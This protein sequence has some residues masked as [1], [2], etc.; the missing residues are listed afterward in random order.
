MEFLAFERWLNKWDG[1]QDHDSETLLAEGVQLAVQRRTALAKLIQFDPQKAL[2][3]ALPASI[4]TR[5]PHE[6]VNELEVPVC[7]RGSYE[8]LIRRSAFGEPASVTRSVEFEGKRYRAFVYGRRER[9]RSK[10][11]IPLHGIAIGDLLALHEHPSRTTL[12]HSP[13]FE[14]PVV[15]VQA[16]NKRVLFES[17]PDAQVFDAQLIAQEDAPGPFAGSVQSEFLAASSRSAWTQGAK[18]LL[19]MRVDFSD[20]PGAPV[21][22]VVADTLIQDTAGFLFENSYGQLSLT[23]KVTPVLRMPKTAAYYANSGAAGQLLGDARAAAKA[24]GS[25]YDTKNFHFDAVATLGVFSYNGLGLL[26]GKGLWIHNKFT[27]EILAH[28]LGH[29]LGLDHANLWHTTDGSII[30]SGSNAEYADPFDM[31]GSV[32]TAQTHFN[33]Y[34]KNLLGW[35]PSSQVTTVKTSGTYRIYA[36]DQALGNAAG[37]LKI[38]KDSRNYWVDF[39]QQIT[40]NP[41][42]MNGADI[43]W[44]PWGQSNGG[45]QLLDMRPDTASSTAQHDKPLTIGMTFSDRENNIHVTPIGKGGTAPESL[46]IVVNFGAFANNFP[47]TLSLTPNAVT[48]AVDQSLDFMASATDPDGDTLAYYWEFGDL[49][50]GTNSANVSKSWSAPGEYIVRCVVTDMKGGTASAWVLV[51]VG[52]PTASYRITGHVYDQH[53]RPVQGVKVAMGFSPFVPSDSNGAFLVLAPPVSAGYYLLATKPGYSIAPSNFTNPIWVSGDLPGRDF[54]ANLL[55]DVND[56]PNASDDAYATNEDQVLVVSSAMGLL[57]NDQDLDGGALTVTLATPPSVG[58]ASLQ[59]NGGFTY[60]PPANFSGT[61]T[62]GYRA[63]DKTLHSLEATVTITVNAVNDAPSVVYSGDSELYGLAGVSVDL[64]AN[65]TDL[66][67]TVDH[68]VWNFGDGS[69]DLDAVPGLQVTHTFA[70]AGA[71]PITV[72]AIDDLG[73]AGPT[74]TLEVFI[75][76]NAPANPLYLSKGLFSLNWAMPGKD[77]LRLAG[78]INPAGLD[79]TGGGPTVNVTVNGQ[80]LATDNLSTIGHSS[81]L[82]PGFKCSINA[83]TGAFSIS[84]SGLSGLNVGLSNLPAGQIVTAAQDLPLSIALSGIGFAAPVTFGGTFRFVYTNRGGSFAKGSFVFQKHRTLDGVFL[85]LNTKAVEQISNGV[86]A[87][88]RLTVSGVIVAASSSPTLP[89]ASDPSVLITVG[90]PLDTNLQTTF[91]MAGNQLHSSGSLLTP[92]STAYT[93]SAG[94]IPGLL[95]FT[96]S[97]SKHTFNLSTDAVPT[98]LDNSLAGT[99]LNGQLLLRVQ[100]YTDLNLT[101]PLTFQTVVELRRS[102]ATSKVW[103]R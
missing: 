13:D 3:Y 59:S 85:A 101:S 18:K 55:V 36:F 50:L 12:M 74:L 11:D 47:P 67:G 16:G 15:A 2:E 33:A 80:Q 96:F 4:R 48:A 7:G 77:S 75:A 92:E 25:A 90:D 72:Y 81:G 95:R 69:P 88:H 60:A 49:T 19:F 39:R 53:G 56:P 6:I 45:T 14:T 41:W 61:V 8:V 83:K 5:L 94:A 44:S 24:L 103:S 62:F 32:G 66:D 10:L 64:T 31:M 23:G 43:H 87:G 70:S 27:L 28:E 29:N 76:G 71:Y 38:A 52:S 98:G 35:L 46:D 79:F 30:G 99:L 21:A 93:A 40:G 34:A 82:V 89:T 73:L 63:H 22:D 84:F 42:L 97:N 54:D 100:V 37:A 91:T 58:Q 26:G 68:L 20:K 78:R 102:K 17:M 1:N 51:N 57:A 65:G 86:S 9:Q